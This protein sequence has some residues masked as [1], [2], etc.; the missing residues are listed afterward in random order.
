MKRSPEHNAKIAA[1]LKRYNRELS[2]EEKSIRYSRPNFA[3]SEETKSLL[4]EQALVDGR[5]PPGQHGENAWNWIHDRE[6]ARR[7]RVLR[8]MCNRLLSR[9]KDGSLRATRKLGYSSEELRSHLESL[10]STGMSWENWGEWHI[11]HIRPVSSFPNGTPL[12]EINSLSNL[13]PLWATENLR[14]SSKWKVRS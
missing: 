4:R 12:T 2:S 13:R 3:H 10:F 8:A 11:D 6:E 9:A 5:R 14:K 7:R 1:S